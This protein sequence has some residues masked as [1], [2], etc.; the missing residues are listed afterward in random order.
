LPSATCNPQDQLT[1]RDSAAVRFPEPILDAGISVIMPA[2]NEAEGVAGTLETVQSLLADLGPLLLG[3]EIIVVDDGSVDGTVAAVEPFLGRG[4]QLVRHVENRG[5]GAALKT[6]IRQ[7]RYD[8]ILIIDADGSYHEQ[9][10]PDL[11]RYR[12]DYEMI[13]GARI[14]ADVNVPLLRRPPKWFLRKLASYLCGRKIPDLNSGLRLIRKDAVER[15]VNILP[16]GFSFTTTITLAMLSSGYNVKYVPIDYRKRAGKSKIR[17]VAD[18]LNFLML[19]F[20]TIMYFNP[21]RVFLPTAVVFFL[22]SFTVGVAS[23]VLF[24]RLMDVT[25]VL[26]FVTGMQFLGL[27]LMADSLNRRLQ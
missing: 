10:I 3:A 19:I 16:D 5:Y 24:N 2:Y 27:G 13:V 26:L 25:T 4:I 18:T 15:F 1:Q 22:L 17:P 20:R 14:G 21:L 12:N 9:Y 23:A 8:W 7:A 6:G 11:L